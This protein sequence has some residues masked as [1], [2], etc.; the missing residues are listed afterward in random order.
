MEKTTVYLT[1]DLQGAIKRIARRKKLSE[2]HVI[3]EAL[4]TYVARETPLPQSIGMLEG[5]IA[6]GVDSTNVKQW[7]R[8]SWI[9]DLDRERA[10]KWTGRPP[11]QPER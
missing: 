4:A 9:K 10:T 2:A 11:D 7:I 3:R 1:E 8:E 5:P 6:P